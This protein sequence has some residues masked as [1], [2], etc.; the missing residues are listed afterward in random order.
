MQCARMCFQAAHMRFHWM[1]LTV[2]SVSIR[3]KC[4]EQQNDRLREEVAQGQ[5]QSAKLRDQAANS[6]RD[7]I[8][9]KSALARL[10]N[11][12]NENKGA[13]KEANEVKIPCHSPSFT[14]SLFYSNH[15]NT[16][17]LNSPLFTLSFLV[18]TLSSALSFLFFC[19]LS[20]Y[21]MALILVTRQPL[22]GSA[23]RKI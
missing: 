23:I 20:M 21:K 18:S 6:D 17:L 4:A 5:G 2:P 22:S 14:H 8:E 7:A 19:F 10:R 11:E 9:A 3:I 1:L 12:M 15:L 16:L 13:A